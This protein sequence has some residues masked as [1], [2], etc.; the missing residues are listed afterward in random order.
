MKKELLNLL[1]Y[2]EKE[3]GID[4][5]FLLDSLERGLLTVYRKKAGLPENVYVRIDRD[6]GD[7]KFLDEA[8]TQLPCPSFPWE[9]IAAQAAK[10]ILIQKIR[11]AEKNAIYQEFSRLQNEIISGRVERFEEGH[12]V[13][14]FGRTEGLL[15][16]HHRLSGDH[17]RVGD[18]VKVFVLEVRKP[19]RGNYQVIVSRTHPD[20]VRRLLEAEVPELKDKLI[21]IKALVRFPGDLTKVAVYSHNEKIDPVGTCIGDKALRIKNISKE[22]AGEKVEII[23]W[24]IDPATFIKNSLSPAQAGK[25]ILNEQAKEAVVLVDDNQLYLAIGK[26]GQNV[27]LASKLTGW[28][29]R[30]LRFSEYESGEKPIYGVLEGVDENIAR[31]LAELGYTTVR[32]LAEAHADSLTRIPGLSRDQAARLITSAI[33]HLQAEGEKK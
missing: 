5:S 10:Q 20:L 13:L 28:N 11:E 7:I 26:K 27:R 23:K 30:V 25:I 4:R 17:L 31:S 19:N 16:Q 9:R 22:L 12:V 2:W 33:E 6:T 1:E 14:S 15:P 3:K 18:N 32:Q 8:G 21:E 24:S 29:I